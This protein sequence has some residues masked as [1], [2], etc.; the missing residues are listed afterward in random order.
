MYKT[1]GVERCPLATSP[2]AHIMQCT[3][4]GLEIGSLSQGVA[5]KL[6]SKLLSDGYCL[7]FQLH[8]RLSNLLL[9]NT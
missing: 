8:H 7:A 5:K 6:S 4:A 2:I 9:T 3:Q 1:I